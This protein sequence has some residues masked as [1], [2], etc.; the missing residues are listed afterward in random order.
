MEEKKRLIEQIAEAV[1]Y[2]A[3]QGKACESIGLTPRR[4]IR[5]K[6]D[7]EDHRNGGYRAYEQKLTEQEKDKIIETYNG[8]DVIHMPIRGAFATLLDKGIYLASPAAVYRVFHERGQQKRLRARS[9]QK[10]KKPIL[11]AESPLRLWCWD[12]TYLDSEI[13]GRYYYLYLVIDLFSRYIVAWQV[14]TVEDGKLAESM[15]A[16]AIDF[17][18]PILKGF[19]VHND[20]GPAMKHKG[21]RNL[22]DTLGISLSYSRPHTSNDNAFAESIF[23]TLKSRLGMPERFMSLEHAR[24]FIT[25]FVDWYNNEH[26]HGSLDFLTPHQVHFGLGEKIQE[27]RNSVLAI[28]RKNNPERFG[29]RYR[30]FRV[31]KVVELHHKTVLAEA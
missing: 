17:W 2:G 28:Q 13:K 11:K 16:E 26:L 8:E 31:P 29:S 24:E 22:L 25:K 19:M 12:I 5:W 7:I 21:F 10:R 6:N 30:K 3:R 4:F 9:L 18:R 23:A 14:E 1:L 15:F 27:E 20:N